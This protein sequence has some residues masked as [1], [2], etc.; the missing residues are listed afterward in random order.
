MPKANEIHARPLVLVVDDDRLIRLFVRATLE[1]AGFRVEE[2]ADGSQALAL[3]PC[4]HPDLVLLDVTMPGMDGFSVCTTLRQMPQGTHTPILMLT[5]LEDEASVN[6]AYEV[7][8]TDFTTKPINTALLGHRVRYLLRA[9]C[10]ITAL[11]QSE[12]ALRQEA[13]ISTTLVQVGRELSASL[14]TP[15]ILERLCQITS[16]VLECDGSYTL[17]QQSEEEAYVAVAGWG[18]GPQNGQRCKRCVFPAKF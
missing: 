11:R 5:G 4:I 7:G 12:Q 1:Q 6:R 14:A 13:Q 16:T 10:A 9:S 15:V 18:I 8:A 17:L 2:A 3:F